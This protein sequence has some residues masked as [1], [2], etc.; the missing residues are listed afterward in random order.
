MDGNPRIVSGTVDMGAY[1]YQGFYPSRYVN[2]NNPY[3]Q[4]PY[5]NWQSAAASIQDAIDAALPGEVVLVSEGIYAA[6]ARELNGLNRLVINKDITV[7]STKG[8]GQT[9]IVGQGAGNGGTNLGNGSIRCVYLGA[10]AVLSGFTLTNGH[11]LYEEVGGGARCEETGVLTNCIL[12]GNSASYAGGVYSGKINNCSLVGN[13]ALGSEYP[14]SSGGGGGAWASTLNNC[15]LLGNFA[16]YAGG[17]AVNSTLQNCALTG[18]SSGNY[19]GGVAACSLINCNITGNS[20]LTGGGGFV[21]Q[22]TN[23]TIIANSADSFGGVGGGTIINCIV[24]YN[25]AES[26]SNYGSDNIAFSCTTPLPPGPGNIDALPLFIN[27]NGW[28]NLR[29]QSNSPCINVGNNDS[30]PEGGLDL[31]GNARIITYTVDMGAYEFRGFFHYANARNENPRWPYDTWENAAT[32]IQDAEDESQPGDTVF[33]TNGIYASGGRAVSGLMT[34][35]VVIDKPITVQSVN[36]PNLTFIVGQGVGEGATN[37][38]DGAIRCVYMGASS[39]LSGFTLTNG[40]TRSS[41]YSS[42]ETDGGGAWCERYAVLTNCT[43]TCNTADNRGGGVLSG[44]LNN[45]T[46]IGNSARF[47]GGA[48]FGVLRNCVVSRNSAYCGGGVAVSELHNCTLT[49]NSA[50][51]EGGGVWEES[52]LYNCIV[53]YNTSPSFPNYYCTDPVYAI[54]ASCIIPLPAS[55]FGNTTNPRCS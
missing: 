39:V 19:G 25:T 3:P 45:C 14:V 44:N 42:A 53:Y 28:A 34:N 5:T 38:G 55:G 11:T 50:L 26:C 21:S 47:G 31:D 20:G 6:G 16:T 18:N 52:S 22:F 33:V 29:L 35:R 4:A 7:R 37:N 48:Y 46:L 30:V 23:C 10:D 12:T 13:S 32:N 1:E 36:G 27:T 24:Y 15:T 43:I 40:H 54:V 2:C 49:G 9:F 51:M 8:P 17:G 41:P